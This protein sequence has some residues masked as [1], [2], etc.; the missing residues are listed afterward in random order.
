MG[1]GD[2]RWEQVWEA[3]L[4][5]NDHEELRRLLA[6]VFPAYA[7]NGGY[8]DRS[9]AAGRPDVRLIAR[10]GGEAVAHIAVAPR[11]VLAGE[12]PMLVGDTGMV[13]VRPSH[14]GTGLGRELLARHAALLAALDLPFG[15]LTCIEPT[16]PYYVAGGWIRLSARFTQLSAGAITSERPDGVAMLLPVGGSASGWPS[17]DVVRNGYEI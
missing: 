9:W 4:T 13:G 1:A 15:F 11:L 2:V 6:S 14:R 16:V 3:E 8:R 7:A 5:T 10:D 17:G 12:R